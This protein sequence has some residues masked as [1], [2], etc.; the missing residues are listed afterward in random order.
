M[1]Q[2]RSR[3]K[4]IGR[5]P[6]A[7]WL[8]V[9]LAV[10]TCGSGCVQRRMMIRS[11][12]PGATVFVDGY[13]IGQTPIA[14]DFVYYGRR[15]IRLIKDGYEPLTVIQPIGPPWWEIPPLD[16]V[17][18]NFV[19]G[20]IRD[21]RV[22]DYQLRPQTVVPTEQLLG[23]AEDLRRQTSGP[24]GG[25]PA[26]PGVRVNPTVRGPVVVPPPTGPAAVPTQP[27]IGGQPV[28]PLPER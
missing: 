10:V 28:Y 24:G 17:S 20:K 1:P 8:G 25:A 5:R 16:F 13:E 3:P 22:F 21:Q 23:R 7:A 27:P 4:T 15:E 12:P 18:E 2:F 14:T 9:V 19:P 6:A 11:N 26:I